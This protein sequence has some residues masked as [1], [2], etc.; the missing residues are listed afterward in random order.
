MSI[1]I[2]FDLDPTSANQKLDEIDKK[3]AITKQTLHQVM[4]LSYAVVTSTLSMFRAVV[5][6]M[7]IVVDAVVDTI[8]TI[9]ANVARVLMAV[10]AA[11]SA[12]EFGIVEA[13]KITVA[14]VSFAATTALTLIGARQASGI[15]LSAEMSINSILGAL[16]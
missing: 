16:R 1:S 8:I 6:A 2:K 7:G 10:A 12:T 3:A 4:E 11:L 14:L 5:S 9:S 13:I 15:V